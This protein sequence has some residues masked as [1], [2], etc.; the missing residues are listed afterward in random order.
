MD[1]HVHSYL[2]LQGDDPIDLGL[3]RSSVVDRGELPHP[4]RRPSGPQ[5][6]G[7]GE[8][9]DRGRGQGGKPQASLMG[10]GSL[11]GGGGPTGIERYRGDATT[12][13]GICNA[14][15]TAPGLK[16]RPVDRQLLGHRV[17][18][19]G[20]SPCKGGELVELLLGEGQPGSDLGVERRLGAKAE[21]DVQERARGGDDHLFG[22]V[23]QAARAAR[24]RRRGRSS[25][26]CARRLHR[27]IA[28]WHRGPRQSA[29]T[30]GSPDPGTGPDR[31]PPPA[32]RRAPASPSRHGRSKSKSQCSAGLGSRPGAHRHGSGR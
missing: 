31:R 32:G 24:E 20:G 19:M 6:G 30:L 25:T 23:A 16:D 2:L 15:R 18:A 3:E 8:R 13:G 28:P 29:A 7:L 11:A 21:R 9:P 26:H 10:H 12:N 22:E 17:P 1:E 5:L 27:R 14:G 4:P